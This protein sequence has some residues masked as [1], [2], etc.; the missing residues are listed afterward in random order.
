MAPRQRV[1]RAKPAT[2]RSPGRPLDPD[3]ERR[4]LTAALEIYGEV[5]WVGFTVSAVAA[6]ASAGK[7]AIYRRWPAKEDLIVDAIMGM[8]AP[9]PSD[10]GSIRGDLIATVESELALYLSPTGIVHLRAQVE[11]KVY[12][13]LFG[14]AMDRYR[15]RRLEAGRRYVK[16]A[17][18]RGELDP[19]VAA[20]LLLDVVGGMTLNRFLATPQHRLETLRRQSRPFAEAVADYA[21]R[22]ITVRD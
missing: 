19:G 22:A 1:E 20:E 7:A 21:L 4:V 6:R 16:A 9:P 2:T 17:T 13:E 5:G 10:T 11:A 14:A 18:Q 15:R 3:L 12:P 8:K